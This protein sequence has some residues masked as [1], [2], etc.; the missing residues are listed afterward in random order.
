MRLLARTS[1]FALIALL[2]VF[3]VFFFP[4]AHGPFSVTHGPAT[5]FRALAAASA[6]FA[7][8]RAAL[9]LGLRRCVASLQAMRMNAA[10]MQR[11]SE[12]FALRC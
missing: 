9:L 6:L 11:A 1:A 12:P 7:T 2:G 10:Q 8:M 3:L 5:A 4:S